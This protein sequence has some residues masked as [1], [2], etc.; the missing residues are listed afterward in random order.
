M[1]PDD[2][3]AAHALSRAVHADYPEREAVLAEKQRLFP[4]GCFVLDAGRDIAGYAFSHPWIDG[5]APSLDTLLGTLPAA[6]SAYFIHDV[7]LIADMRRK[8]HA[9]TVVPLL[10]DVARTSGLRRAALVAVNGADVFWKRF[11]FA[12]ADDAALQGT[13]REK[14]GPRAALMERPL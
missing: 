10:L 11:G 9:A 4:A 5:A 6:P 1:Q 7:T 8:G 12:A 3:P 2:I 13:T 14:Y